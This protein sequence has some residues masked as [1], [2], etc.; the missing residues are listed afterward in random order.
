MLESTWE[1][2]F[3]YLMVDTK[4]SD[5][6]DRVLLLALRTSASN[7]NDGDFSIFSCGLSSS[8]S[9]KNQENM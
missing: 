2:G 7:V 5:G 4:C 9:I 6:M 1:V 3:E 8:V